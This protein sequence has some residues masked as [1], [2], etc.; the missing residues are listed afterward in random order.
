M[1]ISTIKD[2]KI[3]FLANFQETK[4]EAVC[5]HVDKKLNEARFALNELEF[6]TSRTETWKYTRVGRILNAS[7]S[8]QK[9]DKAID[10]TPYLV[11]EDIP[12]VVFVNGFFRADLSR[13]S[14]ES[15]IAIQSFAEAKKGHKIL[16]GHFAEIAYHHKDIFTA[17]NTVHNTGGAVIHVGKEV[18]AQKPIHILHLISGEDTVA[19][20]RHL[21]VLETGAKLELVMSNHSLD[22]KKSFSNV[23]SELFVGENASLHIDKFQQLNHDSFELCTEHVAQESNSRFHI[24]TIT[25]SGL[26]TR[27]NLHIS[28]DGVNCET[29]LFGIY[30]PRN[31]SHVD[32]HTIV[33][34]R[35]PHCVSNELYKGLLYDKSTGVFNGKVFVRQLAQK[36][37]AFQQNANIVMGDDASMNSKPELEIYADDVKCSHGSTTGQFDEEAVFYLKARGICETN[38]RELL[39][40]AFLG[41][42]W[43]AVIHRPKSTT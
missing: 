9:V 40:E 25:Q 34:H 24:N 39:V 41:E 26:W 11:A 8:I 33:D 3:G 4:L 43:E 36:T 37:N 23:V 38:A 32:N 6:P 2:K 20:P 13:L 29:N 7:W 1:S 22:N 31:N 15:G 12:V 28:V 21:V 10:I 19:M 27:N 42:V 17:L 18:Q 35:A 30:S 16:E 5:S 14:S